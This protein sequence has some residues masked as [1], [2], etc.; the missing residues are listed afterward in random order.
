MLRTVLRHWFSNDSGN[1]LERCGRGENFM[2]ASGR[3][4][5]LR[6]PQFFLKHKSTGQSH[7]VRDLE[8]R[9]FARKLSI[10]TFKLS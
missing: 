10:E 8:G 2:T 7:N 6:R 3:V 9:D 1:H 5:H 4:Q